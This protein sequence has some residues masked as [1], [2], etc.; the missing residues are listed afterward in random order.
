VC[1]GF[2]RK[3]IKNINEAGIN[4]LKTMIK[5]RASMINSFVGSNIGEIDLDQRDHLLDFWLWHSEWT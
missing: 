1:L 4:N 5:E 2:T 3:Q